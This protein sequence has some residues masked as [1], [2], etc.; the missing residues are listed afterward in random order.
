MGKKKLW[1]VAIIMLFIMVPVL[2]GCNSAAEPQES[3][4]LVFG[5]IMVGPYNDKGWSQAHY[6]AGEYVE[7]NIP[8]T[9]MISL[10]K[11]NSADRP[12]T[13]TEQVVDDM[14]SKGAKLILTTSDDFQD[15]TDVV[16]EKYPDVIFVNMSGDHA[17]DGTAP[18]NLGNYMPKVEYMKA[19]AGC[20][21]ALATETGHIGYL[22]PLINNETR[23]LVNAAYLGARYCYENYRGKD[24]NDLKFTV[25]WIGFWFN[26]PG[27]TLDPTEVSN[28]L[29]NA[30]AD[31][32]MSGI[33]TTE[34]TTVAKQ[35]ADQGEKVYTL[36]YDYRNACELAPEICLGVPYFNWGPGYVEIVQKVKEGTW[37][38]HWIWEDP[39]WNDIN[40]L[41]TTSAGYLYGPATTDEMKAHL[42]EYKA[43]LSE[44]GWAGLFVGPLNWQDGT[45]WLNEG[46]VANEEDIWNGEQ[47]IEGIEGSDQ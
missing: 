8:G 37:E 26:I 16:A 19:L 32:V 25:T 18:Q 1:L 40:N 27:V 10:D 6:E 24:P 21:A 35:R 45:T 43:Y 28:D 23:R 30:G 9:E 22:G 36:P 11:M 31:V 34:G 38:Q 20:N 14:V 12:E 33:D 41:D 15:D 44:K 5:V 47:L 3:E 13:T 46:E 39:D 29:F 17:K 7:K 42:E 2:S 4:K